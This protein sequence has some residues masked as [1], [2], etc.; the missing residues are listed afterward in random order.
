MAV[1]EQWKPVV[2]FEGYYE[3]SDAGNV[4]S[5]DRVIERPT[6][7]GRFA[8]VPV[9][10]RMMRQ[11]KHP[12]TGHRMVTLSRA[13]KQTTVKVHRIE[14][15]AF[16]GP[17][18]DDQPLGLHWNDDV[19][20]NRLENLRWGNDVDNRLDCIRNGHD[21]YAKR[22]HCGMGHEYTPENF[23]PITGGGRR[24][25]ACLKVYRRRTIERRRAAD[26]NTQEALCG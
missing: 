23:Y 25:K 22:T 6:P 13:G 20:D 12:K 26:C 11:K 14:L 17:P 24:C 5:L 3:V 7:S 4:R 10:G 9:S 18:P 2:G 21:H 19:D 8:T 16:V 15:E 1:D